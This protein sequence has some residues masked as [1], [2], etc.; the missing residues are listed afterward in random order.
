MNVVFYLLLVTVIVLLWFT[1]AFLFK[2]VGK[3]FLR[4]FEDAKNEMSSE[5]ENNF[6]E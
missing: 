4:L 3:L 2:P 6:E 5:E 1:L